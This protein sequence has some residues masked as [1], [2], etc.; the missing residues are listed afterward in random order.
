MPICFKSPKLVCRINGTVLSAADT[1]KN[2]GVHISNDLSW[3]I[4]INEVVKKVYRV[5]NFILHAF[6][7]HDVNLHVSAYQIYV[8]P[9]LDY[10]CF[11]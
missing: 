8:K 6:V 1:I 7:C 2:L 3:L 5:C 10:S 4:H 11:M 9:I